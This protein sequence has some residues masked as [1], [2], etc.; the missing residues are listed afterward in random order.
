MSNRQKADFKGTAF[1]L[2]G[3]W[4]QNF[5]NVGIQPGTFKFVMR[6][7]ACEAAGVN[8][9][10]E[11]CMKQSEGANVIFVGVGDKDTFKLIFTFFNET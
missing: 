2:F 9:R 8:W 10:T 1:D 6:D 3:K 7:N 11:A 5:D 4:C